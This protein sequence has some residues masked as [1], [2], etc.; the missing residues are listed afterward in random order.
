MRVTTNAAVA[1]DRIMINVI[2]DTGFKTG[3]LKSC[4]SDNLATLL[5]IQIG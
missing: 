3:I 4:I 1:I 2:I 5:V